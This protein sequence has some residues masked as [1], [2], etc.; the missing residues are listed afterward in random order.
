MEK[1]TNKSM[2]VC[3]NKKRTSFIA[4]PL[5]SIE[6]NQE[7]FYTLF[8]GIIDKISQIFFELDQ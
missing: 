2:F 4:C 1:L 5:H 7:D 3:R 6:I 8:C